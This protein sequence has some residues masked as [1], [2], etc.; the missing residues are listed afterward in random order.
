MWSRGV[1]A[2]EGARRSAVFSWTALFVVSLVLQYVAAFAPSPARAASGLLAGTVAGFEVDGDLKS[3]NGASNPGAIPDGL[4]ASLADGNDWLQG[5]GGTGVVDPP[6]D[7]DRAFIFHDAV[8]SPNNLPGDPT[9]DNSA[10]GGGNKEDD[11]RDWVYVNSAGPNA[12][13]DFRHV[14]AYGKLAGN[15]DAYVFLGAERVEGNGTMVVD[16]E[17][18]RKPFKIYP[19]GGPAKPNRSEGDVLIS[20]EYSNGGTNPVV[21]I[22]RITNV[23]NY[24][25]GQ[26]VDFVKIG[27]SITSAAVRSATNFQ[28]LSSSGLGY[29]VEPFLF[30]EASVNISALGLPLDC[31]NF[32]TGQ[33]RSR[34]GGSPQ[35]S[36]LKD[37]APAF[38]FDLSTCARIVIEKVDQ[39]GD[40]IGGATFRIDPYPL[41]PAPDPEPAYLDVTDNDA[42]DQDS[43]DGYIELDPCIPGDTYTITEVTAP[44]GYIKDP[45][46]QQ[47]TTTAGGTARVTF[48]NDLGSLAWEKRDARDNLLGGARFHVTGPYG[49][50]VTVTDN[51]SHDKD[52]DDGQFKLTRL[53]LGE[54]TV[55][56]VAAP[57]GYILDPTPHSATVTVEDRSAVITV[58]YVNT[59]GSIRWVKNGPNGTDLL[60]GATFVVSPDPLDGAGDLTVEDCVA[61]SDADCTGAD[62]DNDAGEFLI[63]D[64]RA[65]TYSITETVAPAGYLVD[66]DPAP[67]TVSA[68]TPNPVVAAGTFVDTLGIIRWVK[69]GPGGDS[70]LLGGATFTITPSPVTGT[71]SLV[72]PDC[73]AATC[74]G[75][76]ADETPGEFEVRDAK[77]GIEYTIAET[78]PPAGYVG[79]TATAT[80]TVTDAEPQPSVPAGTFVN[81]LG[82]I[83][84]VKN[85]P[86]GD[87]D[88]VGGAIFTVTPDPKTGSGSLTVVDCVKAPCT[89]ADADPDPGEFLV[90]DAR[91]GGPYDI[92]EKTPPDGYVGT[93][94]TYA[95][96][97]GSTAATKDQVVPVGTFVNRLGSISWQKNGPNGTAKLDGATFSITGTAG[98]AAGFSQTGLT[99]S[100]GTFFVGDL[101][102]GSY[103]IC[104][105]AAPAGY[106]RDTACETVDLT[107]ADKDQALPAGTF[108]NRLGSLTWEKHDA[109][110]ALLGGATFEVTGTAGPAIGYLATLP[111]CIAASDALC[112]GEDKDAT[113]GGFRIVGLK[114]GTYTVRETVAPA[115]FLLDPDVEA[116]TLTQEAPDASISLS[117]ID[118]L[119]SIAWTKDDG[120]DP[121]GGATFR[122][123]PNPYGSGD[124]LVTDNVAPD[125][126][127]A[128]GALLL[129]DVPTG[130]YTITETAAPEGYA[131]DAGS[132]R[133]TVDDAHPAG[134]VTCSF[135]NPPIEPTIRIVKTA[136]LNAILQA[137][138]GGTYFIESFTNNTTYKYVVTNTGTVRLVDVTV[139]DDN[140]TPGNTA[141]DVVVCTRASLGPGDSFNCT[142]QTTIRADTTNVAVAAGVSA[143]A[144]LPASDDDDA[145]VE[146]VGPAIQVVKTAGD[147]ADGA[148]YQTEVFPDNVSYYYVVTNTGE[149]TLTGVTLSDDKVGP[150]SC[151]KTAL[152]PGESMTCTAMVTVSV[153][154]TNV[155]TVQGTSPAGFPVNDTDDAVVDVLIPG[156]EI[157]KTAGGAAD[158]ATY[159]A[160]PGELV[161]YT[162]EVTNTGDL[163]LSGL[164]VR[165]DNGTPAYPGHDFDALCA[166]TTLAPGA[167][168]TCAASVTFGFLGRTNVA[169]ASA[170]T[171][172]ELPV[173][174]SDDA[175]VA[176]RFLSISKSN[177]THGPVAPGTTVHYSLTLAVTNGP[178][179][180]P[181]EVADALPDD[182]GSPAS[183]SDGGLYD[184]GTNTITWTLHN[185]ADG[186]TLTYDVVIARTTQGDDYLNRATITE[187]P[188][189]IDCTDTSTVPVWRMSIAKDNDRPEALVTGDEIH[190]TLTLSVQNG[191]IDAVTIVDQLPAG[192]GGVTDVS[193]G[194]VYNAA[195]NT[196]TWELLGVDNGDRLT[197]TAVVLA[198]ATPGEHTNTATI[199]VGPCVEDECDDTSTVTVRK[200]E[201]TIVKGVA[202]NTGG[203]DPNLHVPRAKIGDTLTFTLQYTLANGPVTNAVI[204]DVLPIGYGHPSAISD[205][206]TYDAATRTIT[207]TWPI[208]SESGQVSYRVKVLETAPDQPQ[209]LVNVA[210]IVSDQT[211]ADDDDAK[212]AVAPPPAE[213]TAT[214]R[215]TPPPTDASLD[216]GSGAGLNLALVLLAIAGLVAVIGVLT[217]AP[218]RARRRGPRR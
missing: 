15:G 113:A 214:P 103:E 112:S 89:G 200:P 64:A 217:P 136:G 27:D 42:N 158:G 25:D 144:G 10:Y 83:A 168:T 166:E 110:G 43:R 175:V 86:G 148:T 114:L 185:V 182:F 105:T 212:V 39:D 100:G 14:M 1:T 115:G 40:H 5:A 33:I 72:V 95:V 211:P 132:C 180:G 215:V 70:D 183:I 24:S 213:E 195:S 126:N 12:K 189:V 154:T 194:G 76:D 129:E 101:K 18:N 131:P 156:I 149:V 79:S 60:G 201:L 157:I 207:W 128:A 121:L 28:V 62:R 84:W 108:V 218:A 169:V 102:L 176:V 164:V 46:P 161:T 150:I 97:V 17:L 50:D 162:Y 96:T 80:V 35:S 32:S 94:A 90:T 205:G 30:A 178:I 141:D 199:E 56:E 65:G 181:V 122:V 9:P 206:G 139:T 37:A 160:E 191:P 57:D 20:L 93:S 13:T 107:A 116:A 188:C 92:A 44:A 47:V 73:V 133:V 87:T 88:L 59:L 11:T 45:A 48:T 77:A 75:P 153:D 120:T 198:S 159:F 38:G 147:A 216:T 173:S 209:P 184:A 68:D 167:S 196:I 6:I 98:P 2:R 137:P 146:I 104:E 29:E 197:Y 85:G 145:V 51:D 142:L 186:K 54:Y 81:T 171:P 179:P 53:K 109:D 49:Y 34:T 124:L 140:G 71:G 208:L 192:I 170:E 22:Y 4:I 155:A 74:S 202:G 130:S 135:T 99:G 177:S 19:A 63:T 152:E 8:D 138:D 190:Y 91:V 117:F 16:F 61:A 55:T 118:T 143:G 172:E 210:T 187:G 165:D 41:V 78:T 21:T 127:P 7:P 151:P 134:T 174:D 69:N 163:T 36:Q 82:S 119:G 66:P 52:A 31:L 123:H 67:V 58:D 125:A 3:G 106:V 23:H 26:T 193:D 111:D 204:T 203:T